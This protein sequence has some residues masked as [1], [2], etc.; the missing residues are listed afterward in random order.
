MPTKEDIED[1]AERLVAAADYLKEQLD[2]GAEV[3]E[4][5][6]LGAVMEA[7]GVLLALADSI[8]VAE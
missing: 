2:H 4:S 5:Q 3:A 6:W 1:A 8:I 7:H